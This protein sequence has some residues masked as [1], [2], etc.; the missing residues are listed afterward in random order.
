MKKL[1]I[2]GNV[3]KIIR[4]L[5]DDEVC[6]AKIVKNIDDRKIGFFVY[7]DF[8]LRVQSTVSCSLFLHQTGLNSCEI[9]I[10][11]SGGASAIGITWGAHK[12]IENKVAEGILNYAKKMG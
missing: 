1:K 7:E 9:T 4:F 12:N 2:K 11:G 8:Y 3:D 10:V 6:K 5:S